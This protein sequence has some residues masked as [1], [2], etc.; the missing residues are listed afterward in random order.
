MVFCLSRNQ[1]EDSTITAYHGTAQMDCPYEELMG[2]F[3]ECLTYRQHRQF[4]LYQ[5]VI[6]Q[7]IKVSQSDWRTVDLL[8]LNTSS[9]LAELMESY[10]L[11]SCKRK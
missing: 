4:P 9:P 3:G 11:I 6:R 8:L 7:L 1:T 5:K 2:S 10:P